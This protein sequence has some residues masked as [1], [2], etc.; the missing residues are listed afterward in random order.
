MMDGH[1]K[2]DRFVVPR[3]RPNAA[4]ERAVEVVEGRERTKGN[5]LE[6]TRPGHRA[7][8]ARPARSS[9]YVRQHERTGH[10]PYPLVR[11]GVVTRGGSRMR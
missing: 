11:S 9:A 5:G 2:S 6:R 4:P 10:H 7:G 8:S 1:G 3:K